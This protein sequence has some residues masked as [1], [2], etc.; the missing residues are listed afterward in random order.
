MNKKTQRKP[1]PVQAGALIS[2]E[3]CRRTHACGCCKVEC[4]K[5]DKPKV[6]AEDRQGRLWK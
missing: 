6:K 2:E 3:S 4:E 1:C 5:Q